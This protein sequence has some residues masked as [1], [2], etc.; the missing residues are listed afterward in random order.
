MNWLTGITDSVTQFSQAYATIKNA[1]NATPGADGAT[2]LAATATPAAATAA[3]GGN[4][5]TM[6]L[7]GGGVLVAGI[8]LYAGLK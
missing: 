6:L 4:T 5:T 7:I 8:A 1:G 2:T 3:A